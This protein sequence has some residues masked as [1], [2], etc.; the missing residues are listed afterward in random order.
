[1]IL[2][3]GTEKD[4]GSTCLFPGQ[5]HDHKNQNPHSLVHTLTFYLSQLPVFFVVEFIV[6]LTRAQYQ[7]PEEGERG[8][9]GALKCVRNTNKHLSSNERQVQA[10]I[11]RG[12]NSN[13][14]LPEANLLY[15]TCTNKTKTRAKSSVG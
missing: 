2:K 11:S 15:K 12:S 1:M 8:H 4:S 3:N 7:A 6:L 10:I 13:N 9:K 14:I 5:P